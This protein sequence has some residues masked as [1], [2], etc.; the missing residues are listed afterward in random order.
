MPQTMKAI[1]KLAPG[2]GA[3]MVDV[4]IPQ[5]AD[6]E[7]LIKV[8]TTS[9]CGT[10]GHIFV[11][12]PWSQSRIKP[13]QTYGHEFCGD[14]VEVGRSVKG[15]SVGGYVSCDSH[16]PCMRCYQCRAGQ[17]HICNRLEILGVDRDGCFAEYIALPTASL[18]KNAPD[19]LPEI[20]SVQDPL[21]NA[22]YAT[23][24]TNVSGKTMAV[25]GMGPIGTF[26]VGVARASGASKIFALG[27]HDYRLDLGRKM[28]AD[29][30]MNANEM[31]VVAPIL[32]ATGGVGVDVVLDMAGTPEAVTDGFK[33]VRK[34]GEFVAFGI[35]QRPFTFDYANH[36]VFKGV[37]VY[38]INGRLLF[39]TWHQMSNLLTSGRLDVSP[40]I[41]H[42]LPWTEYGEGFRL[43]TTQPVRCGKVVLTVTE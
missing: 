21:G 37:T 43:M 10:D 22:V 5:I 36:I 32:E 9:I 14:I 16:I 18:V 24:V 12:D 30:C 40:V 28:G 19:L 26:A 6:D 8:R 3:E 27:H 15:F 17:P 38:G 1:R 41:T 39:Q 31:D 33:V 11:W 34:G 35:P 4:P 25:F 20:A 2:P 7:V 23:L 42:R 29:V 13:P